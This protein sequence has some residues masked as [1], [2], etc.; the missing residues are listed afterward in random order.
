MKNYIYISLIFL[1]SASAF[2][3]KKIC[4]CFE[5]NTKHIT[6]KMS[7]DSTRASFSIAKPGFETQEDRDQAME[8]YKE[9]GP[10][11]YPKFTI[12]YVA[13]EFYRKKSFKIDSCAL[14]LSVEKFRHRNFEYPEDTGSSSII[15]IKKILDNE[16]FVWKAISLE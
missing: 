14:L 16:Y 5:E 8:A 12:G 1:L 7:K 6:L 4:I 13:G 10:Y 9:R 15:F 2:A 3:Q 11:N